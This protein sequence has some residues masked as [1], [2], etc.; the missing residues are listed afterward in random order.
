MNIAIVGGGNGGLNIIKSFSKI[1]DVHIMMVVDKDIGAPGMVLAG[2]LGIPC[3]TSIDDIVFSE[4]DLVIEVTGNDK[5]TALISEKCCGRCKIIDSQGARLIMNLVQRDIET[6]E[7]LNN[8]V[9]AIDY[10]AVTVQKQSME[11]KNSI[12]GVHSVI[13]SLIEFAKV[14]DD[15]INQS[16]EIIQY[17]NNIAQQTKILGL[18]ATIEA[19]RAGENG[20]AFGVVA[21]EI[22]KLANDSHSNSKTIKDILTRLSGEIKNIN[23]VVNRLQELS[24]LQ[25]QVSDNMS[26]A[27]NFLISKCRK[28]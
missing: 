23:M 12:D 20:R 8:Q 27:M 28:D 2:E 21:K 24:Q 25:K 10:A 22:Q 11:I 17:V 9:D 26:D 3:S 4:I 16:D 13:A 1:N 6:L 7:K 5:V 18:N 19:A 14:S 15:Y